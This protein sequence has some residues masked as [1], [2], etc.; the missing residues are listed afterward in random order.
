VRPPADGRPGPGALW[1]HWVLLTTAGEAAGF[2]VPACAAVLVPRTW[3]EGPRFVVLV[4]AGACEGAVLG[5]AQSR[6]LGRWLPALPAAAW[7]ARTALAAALAWAVGL[8]PAALWGTWSRLPA[9]E[10]VPLA[11]VAALVLLAS[12][13]TAQWTVLRHHVR[14][15][16]QWIGWTALG[17][18]A[19]LTVFTLVSTPLWRPGQSGVVITAIGVLAG[20][21][22]AGTFAAVTGWGLVRMLPRDRAVVAG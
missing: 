4:V 20:T 21:L 2:L 1:R 5:W 3:G 8:L 17:W 18:M 11:V 14:E 7:I 13:G 19:A 15:S 9:A 10:L 12:I 6:A 22:M 16:A